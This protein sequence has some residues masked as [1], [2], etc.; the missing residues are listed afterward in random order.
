MKDDVQLRRG[1]E[2]MVTGEKYKT[3]GI[4]PLYLRGEIHECVE[5]LNTRSRQKGRGQIPGVE[6]GNSQNM[7]SW[8]FGRG[9]RIWDLLKSPM[10]HIYN[11]TVFF[12]GYSTCR[13][14]ISGQ[15]SGKNYFGKKNLW[16]QKIIH[17]R[18]SCAL[19]KVSFNQ[20]IQ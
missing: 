3:K 16:P 15:L 6:W 7:I 5:M 4:S 2:S 20:S 13:A 1:E 8:K 9:D 12:R 14:G 18:W 19:Y 10:V 11:L 17:C